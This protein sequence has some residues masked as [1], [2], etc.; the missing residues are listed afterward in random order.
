MPVPEEQAQAKEYHRQKRR[1]F[2]AQ[3]ILQFLGLIF[4]AFT[5]FSLFLKSLAA[6]WTQAPAMILSFYFALVS[7]FFLCADLPLDWYSGYY[8]EK[9]YALTERSLLSWA[10]DFAKKALLGFAFYLFLLEVLYV[11]TARL[12]QSWWLAAWGLWM[13]ISLLLGK[14]AHLLILPLFY[15]CEPLQDQA[16]LEKIQDL[17]QRCELPLREIYTINLSRTTKKANAAVV[18]FGRTRRVL[19]AD[20]LL[21]RFES[22]EILAVLAHEIAHAKKQHVL[23]GVTWNALLSLAVF[24]AAYLGVNAGA[25]RLG[26]SGAADIAAF[27]LLALAGLTVSF[28]MM[29]L[30]N[31]LSRFFEREADAFAARD[32]AL[33]AGLA[34]ALRRLGELNLAEFDPEPWVEF[35]LYSHPSLKKRIHYASRV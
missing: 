3:I 1:C 6:Q 33:G 20:N 34:A 32:M 10:A 16:L 14:A 35:F 4:L 5:P 18:G 31:A 12:P 29:P 9:K 11:L 17:A 15:R 27:P 13:V 22:D 30:N 24:Y 25:P 23:K 7:L 21:A 2:F 26:F 8:M 19:L 28:I